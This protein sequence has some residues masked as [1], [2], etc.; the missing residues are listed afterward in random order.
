LREQFL[1]VPTKIRSTGSFVEWIEDKQLGVSGSALVVSF[2]PWQ[3]SFP[4]DAPY[5]FLFRWV[6]RDLS[7]RDSSNTKKGSPCFFTAKEVNL[8][9]W[10]D[11]LKKRKRQKVLREQFLVVSTKIRS[12]GSFVEWREDK[13]LGVSGSALVVVSFPPWQSSFSSNKMIEHKIHE[14]NYSMLK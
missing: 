7:F 14:C 4:S 11:R 2:R 6:P 13:E 12:T 5:L 3:S 9:R 1:V 10:L 8:K